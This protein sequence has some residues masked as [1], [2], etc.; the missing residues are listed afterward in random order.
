[1]ASS[2]KPNGHN[3]K[4]EGNISKVLNKNGT[5]TTF[6]GKYMA[7]NTNFNY[8]PIGGYKYVTRFM[9]PPLIMFSESTTMKWTCHGHIDQ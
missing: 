8:L 9:P 2:P 3:M 4:M 6:K 7:L 1:M 5:F